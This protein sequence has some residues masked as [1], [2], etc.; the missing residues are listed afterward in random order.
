LRVTQLK[1]STTLLFRS[2]TLLALA[3]LCWCS[4]VLAQDDM[5]YRVRYD[6]ATPGVVHISLGLNVFGT[7]PLTLIMPRSFPGGYVQ[8]PY[9]PYVSNVKAFGANGDAIGV[10]REELGPR[11][12]I[13]QCCARVTRIEYDVDV[14]QM[15]HEIFAASDSS[16]I[17]DGYVGLLGYSVFAFLDGWETR[18]ITLEIAAPEGWP[19]FATLA[20]NVPAPTA[21]LTAHAPDYYALADSQIMI[22]PKL[23]LRRI[24][25][26][27]PL[28][29]AAYAEGDADMARESALAREA[30]DKVIA[31]FGKAPFSN[32]SV[33]LE[34]L[35]PV[36]PR[37][38]YGFSMEHLNSG[39]FYLELGN[40]LTSR[41]TDSEKEAHRFN[42]AHHIAHSWIPKRAYG[43][44]YFPF[45]W[46]MEPVIDTIWFNEGFGRY[47]AIA[48]L[49]DAL[50]RDEAA[51]YRSTKLDR[52]RSIVAAAPAFLQRMPMAELSREGSFL[53]ADDFRV[54]MNLFARGALMA[55]EMDD[56]IRAQTEGKKSLRDALRH[57]MDW[58]E[59]N[60]RAF[61]TEE[62]PAI[63][64]EATGVNTADILDRWMQ[65]P[66]QPPQ[67]LT[68]AVPAPAVQ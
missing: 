1:N 8:R 63:F 27:I 68:P 36:S 5:V 19:V 42:Y 26:G 61:R 40:A 66:I 13:G 29:V 62:L 67:L 51:R 47:A 46:E 10:R 21:A 9:D 64:R 14:V 33:A 44:G 35:K 37:H 49:A 50:P 38:E 57:L 15:E 58:S 48:A 11:W 32:Y 28:F 43:A 31:Y 7:A 30:L 53:Y 17:R 4:P 34:F 41:S 65:A 16:K 3:A 12:S 2:A 52:L 59:Q 55:A 20:P 6:R 56:R 24:D 22:G 54:G 45:R 60:Q 39:T 18:S 25:S 23:Q